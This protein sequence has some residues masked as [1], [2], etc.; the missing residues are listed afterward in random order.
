MINLFYPRLL[1]NPVIL[2]LPCFQLSCLNLGKYNS[3]GTW[4]SVKRYS[5]G[6]QKQD[7]S[8]WMHT[9]LSVI[10][11]T[12]QIKMLP[13]SQRNAVKKTRAIQNYYKSSLFFTYPHI[14][15]SISHLFLPEI[16]IIRSLVG[17][18]RVLPLFVHIYLLSSIF[19][20]KFCLFLHGFESP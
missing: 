15:N 13:E 4:W 9:K 16:K 14:L 12:A 7:S 3:R 6:Q 2:N 17:I 1:Y 8:F 18:C 10:S 5:K 11:N 20:F 19:F